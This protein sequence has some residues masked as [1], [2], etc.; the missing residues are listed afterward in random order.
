MEMDTDTLLQSTESDCPVLS[1]VA[2]RKLQ[3]F[4]H[5]ASHNAVSGPLHR[6]ASISFIRK[7]RGQPQ[8]RFSGLVSAPTLLFVACAAR[9]I[10]G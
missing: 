1:E 6:E 5:V 8:A 9:T 2:V 4:P 7:R 3:R 10:L